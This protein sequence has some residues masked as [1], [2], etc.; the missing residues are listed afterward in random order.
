[1]IIAGLIGPSSGKI[2]YF[3]Y[4]KHATTKLSQHL[5]LVSLLPLEAYSKKMKRSG[6]DFSKPP[7]LGSVIE[8][9]P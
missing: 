5:S 3:H 8:A 2:V 4:T 7:L 9:R 1:V 6:Y